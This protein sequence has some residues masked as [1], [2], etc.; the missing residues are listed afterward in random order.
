MILA[1]TNPRSTP[2]A[3]RRGL[4]RQEVGR[5]RMRE[6]RRVFDSSVHIGRL[7]GPRT[8]FVLRAQDVPAMDAALRV[9]VLCAL[10]EDSPREWRTT[11]LVRPGTPEP[12]DLDRQ[13]FAAARAA[14]GILDRSCDGCYVLT[15]AGWR[16]LLT[17]ETRTWA[18]LRL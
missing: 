16:D 2:E 10:L 8:G 17:D 6:S 9:D 3:A 12:H 5:F 4:L 11:W 13:W 14:F 7:A 18:R 15:R 1:V